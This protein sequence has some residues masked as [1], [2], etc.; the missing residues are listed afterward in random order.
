MIILLP[1]AI[2]EAKESISVLERKSNIRC[3]DTSDNMCCDMSNRGESIPYLHL[4][5]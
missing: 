4:L 1:F 3:D 2:L 5:F